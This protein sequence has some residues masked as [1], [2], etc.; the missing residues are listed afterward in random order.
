MAIKE[1]DD[2]QRNKEKKNPTQVEE[3]KKTITIVFGI[4]FEIF[5]GQPYDN[6]TSLRKI[7]QS[8][9]Y[10]GFLKISSLEFWGHTIEI[11][12]FENKLLLVTCIKKIITHRSF[13][14]LATSFK[15]CSPIE[16]I[17]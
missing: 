9:P 12:S 3:K 7:M 8:D 1:H 13:K 14:K 2:G 10:T 6:F 11:Y 4:V 16:I 17:V 15:F 5:H